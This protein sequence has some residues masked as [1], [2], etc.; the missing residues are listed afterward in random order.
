MHTLWQY[1]VCI[2]NQRLLI[3]NAW[4][5]HLRI[6]SVQNCVWNKKEE[7]WG[8][9]KNLPVNHRLELPCHI[10]FFFFKFAR[11]SWN[12][13]IALE[14]STAHAQGRH[15]LSVFRQTYDFFLG[16]QRWTGVPL[17]HPLCQS[18][19]SGRKEICQNTLLVFLLVPPDH[20]DISWKAVPGNY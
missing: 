12:L 19:I 2:H 13:F 1:H 9:K 5:F 18:E 16:T 4:V 3:F 7:K 10:G 14:P 17:P 8:K 6:K 15:H 20:D 11:T